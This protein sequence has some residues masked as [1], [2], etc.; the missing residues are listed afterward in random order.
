MTNSSHSHL[1]RDYFLHP[2]QPWQQS[3]P[4]DKSMRLALEMPKD[5]D[6]GRVP[7]VWNRLRQLWSLIS[8]HWPEHWLR[9][10]T[11]SGLLQSVPTGVILHSGNPLKF[12]GAVQWKCAALVIKASSHAD[13]WP[14]W[15]GKFCG[16]NDNHY[17]IF[18]IS[19]IILSVS[20]TSILHLPGQ[21]R[22]YGSKFSTLKCILQQNLRVN[23]GITM[24][25]VHHCTLPQGK[26]FPF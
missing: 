2:G 20:R 26:Q 7:P 21:S 18:H 24:L 16:M 25:F 22:S 9:G 6:P 19:P 10:E 5:Q 23:L 1:Q 11:H 17:N 8:W 3:C 4:L 12:Q 14:D 13:L 15:P